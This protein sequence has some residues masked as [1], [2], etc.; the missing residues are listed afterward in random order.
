MQLFALDQNKK[1][2]PAGY[3]SRQYD[4]QCLEC[5]AIVRVRAG[6][7]RRVHFY[8][9]KNATGCSLHQKSMEHI[10]V[11]SFLFEILPPRDCTLEQPFPEVK[12]IADVAW[13]SQK[14]VFEIQCSPISALE[15]QSRNEDYQKCGYQVVWILH[16][17]TFNQ[18][19]L[20]AAEQFLGDSPHYFTNMNEDG[21]GMI[22]DYYALIEANRRTHR[23]AHF[24]VQLNQPYRYP[25]VSPKVIPIKEMAK[26]V[27]SW[28]FYFSGDLFDLFSKKEDFA[29]HEAYFAEI[30]RMEQQAF[31]K[32]PKPQPV[33]NF[34]NFIDRFLIRPYLLLLQIFIEKHCR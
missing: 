6:A 27:Q 28:N 31:S 1:L 12:R 23:L 7:H 3:A 32:I 4:Y 5:E 29:K 21:E 2:V 11:Q 17:Q 10:Q 15:V 22:Y 33:S 24:A 25:E 9:L 26:R 13:F 34:Y 16:E 8:H 30:Y 18:R 19:R 20:S 14:L